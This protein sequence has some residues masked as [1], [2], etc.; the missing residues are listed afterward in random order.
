MATQRYEV[1]GPVALMLTTTASDLD[2]E[3]MNR[4]VVV[5][6]DESSEQTAAIHVQ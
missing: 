3:L 2:P 4:C 6:V 5:G 1:E